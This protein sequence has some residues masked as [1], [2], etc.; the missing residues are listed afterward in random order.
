MARLIEE[1]A[2]RDGYTAG[3]RYVQGAKQRLGLDQP[4][5]TAEQGTGQLKTFASLGFTGKMKSH[6]PDGWYLPHDFSK[7]AIILETKRSDANLYKKSIEKEL[8][9]NVKITQQKYHTVIG[10]LYNQSDLRVFKNGQEVTQQV[11]NT[12][13]DKSYYIGFAE[14]VKIDKDHI[15]KLTRQINDVLHSEFKMND[16]KD[17]MV[18]TA[19]ALVVQ[20]FA[21]N[22]NGLERF[23]N[24]TY[25]AIHAYIT[26]KLAETIRM[27]NAKALKPNL[28]LDILTQKFNAISVAIENKTMP[29]VVQNICEISKLINSNYWNGEDVMAIFF[30]EF[31]RYAGKTDNG[32]VFTPE[33][34]V[35][36]IDRLLDVNE[37]DLILDATCGSGT[38]LVK[39]M[40]RMIKQAGGQN[41]PK[42]REIMDKQL[43]GIEFDPQIYALACANMLIHK[44]GKTNLEQMDTRTDE[45]INW[46]KN[47]SANLANSDGSMRHIDGITKVLMNPPFE[48]KYG[49]MKIVANVMNSVPKDTMCAFIMPDKQLEKHGG[50]KLLKH[51]TLF[52]IIKM[53]ENIFRVGTTT[54][55]FIFKTGTPQNGRK[56][57]GYYI[58]D[59]GLITVKNQGRQD[60]KNAWPA[61]EDYWV[62]AIN[63]IHDDYKY[64]T[65][66]IIDP[67]KFL[68]YQMPKKP[69]EIHEE[70]F[71]KTMM[72]YLMFEQQIDAKDFA[73]KLTKKTLYSSE[74]DYDG[75]NVVI[76]LKGGDSDEN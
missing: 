51:H 29:R 61:L 63:E 68:S 4:D 25:N 36:L 54:S 45:A 43:Y 34:M 23:E 6:K 15:Y 5:S 50:A 52:K 8:L 27:E 59:D 33:H 28:K 18:F 44:D 56:I 46:I 24:D 74:I 16:L 64:K 42:A 3:N 32:Q 12:L 26:Q 75:D 72:D 55:I 19:C 69:F 13:E 7:P 71:V 62:E 49:C 48:A 70:D 47:I 9:D 76:K 57:E 65:K 58:E 30:N 20:R 31:N 40:A 14:N 17:R 41:T 39:S 35:S 22:N 66:Q 10:I 53:P 1:D 38:F 37:D 11:S 67:D 21:E 2:V 60:V 73:N